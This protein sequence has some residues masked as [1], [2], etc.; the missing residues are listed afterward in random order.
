MLFVRFSLAINFIP[1][2]VNVNPN[3]P[4]HPTLPSTFGIC[5]FVSPV[6]VSISVLQTSSSVPFSFL[7]VS[8]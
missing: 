3:P 6:G 4:V 1:S 8:S 5:K 2:S 7:P